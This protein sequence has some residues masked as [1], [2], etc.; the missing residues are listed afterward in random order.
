MIEMTQTAATC[1][2]WSLEG[3]PWNLHHCASPCRI[4]F[5]WTPLPLVQVR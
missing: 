2:L 4:W 3:S 5:P 1:R